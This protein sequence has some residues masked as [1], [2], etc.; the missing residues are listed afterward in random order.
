MVSN[1]SSLVFPKLKS[2]DCNC[3]PSMTPSSPNGGTSRVYNI[4]LFL[5]ALNSLTL[6]LYFTSHSKPPSSSPSTVN[7]H[8][9]GLNHHYLK[10]WPILSSYLPWS[11]YSP[12]PLSSCEAFFGSGFSDRHDLLG[13]QSD[14]GS[15]GGGGWFKCW[16]NDMLR[17][18]VCEGGRI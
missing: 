18:S 11:H 14:G 7:H 15:G 10:P 9:N 2:E 12:P 1:E 17:S 8:F 6:C 16:H 4:L 3:A 5:F 13:N